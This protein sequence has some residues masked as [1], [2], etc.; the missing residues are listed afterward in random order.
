VKSKKWSEAVSQSIVIAAPASVDLM[1]DPIRPEWVL[2]G[3]PQARSKLLAR[4]KDGGSTIVA[5][6]C[7]AG[8]F[9]W[10]YTIDETVHIISGEV[11]ITNEKNEVCRLGPGDMAFFPAGSRSTWRV[12]HE[13]RKLAFCR[14][15]MPLPISF[16]LR[17]W[18]KSK[19]T[20]AALLQGSP[21]RPIGGT[22]SG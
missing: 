15:C 21:G 7:T 20:L 6:S 16:F 14:N 4:S 22:L 10:H 17:A 13:V 2:E 9:N 18:N 3:Q 19:R 12:P 1:P 8:R 11:F 5:W